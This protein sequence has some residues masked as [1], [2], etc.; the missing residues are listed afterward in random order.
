MK[1]PDLKKCV[2]EVEELR[3]LPPVT[4]EIPV[5]AAL[6]LISYVQ[7]V[8]R[9]PLYRD[10]EFGKMAIDVAKQLQLSIDPN[11]ENVKLLEL[12]WEFHSDM[13]QSQELRDKVLRVCESVTTFD[14]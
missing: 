7:L 11:F 10:S 1:E 4:I 9:D 2:Q 5:L 3:H 8:T 6:T 13:M 14:T 12:G